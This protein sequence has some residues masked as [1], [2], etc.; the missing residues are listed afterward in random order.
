MKNQR[1]KGAEGAAGVDSDHEAAQYRQERYPRRGER[2]AIPAIL[3]ALLLLAGLTVLLPEGREDVPT[4][5]AYLYA[6][7]EA[8]ERT[9][10]GGLIDIED[11]WA[12]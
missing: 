5:L 12:I 4:E 11:A 8:H 6:A 10:V 9:A 3:L 2:L 7:A 1:D